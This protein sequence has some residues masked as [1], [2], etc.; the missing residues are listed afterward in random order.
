MEPN[1]WSL[2]CRISSNSEVDADEQDGTV[3]DFGG[4]LFIFFA[5]LELATVKSLTIGSWDDDAWT[6]LSAPTVD[7]T[8]ALPGDAAWL[9]GTVA[10]SVFVAAAVQ[11]GTLKKKQKFLVVPKRIGCL[12]ADISN[13]WSI[14][15]IIE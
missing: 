9:L 13:E 3:P 12:N 2:R 1:F 7:K 10:A 5:S 8:V 15:I 14:F 11:T 4:L 6:E